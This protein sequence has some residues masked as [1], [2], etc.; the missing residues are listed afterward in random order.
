MSMSR[1]SKPKNRKTLR[2]TLITLAVIGAGALSYAGYLLHK[3]DTALKQ[4]SQPIESAVSK[5]SDSASNSASDSKLLKPMSFLLAGVDS[6]D[7]SGGSMNT[8]V[9]MMVSLNPERRSATIVSIPRDFELKPKAF[10]ISNQKA[11]YY[12]AYYNNQDKITSLTKTREFFGSMFDVPLDYMAVIDFDGFREVVDELGGLDINVD[13]DMRY[14]DNWDG[15]NINLKKGLQ[16]L[17]GKNTLDFLRYR[18]SNRGTEE[19]SDIARNE[20]QQLVLDK[21]LNKMTSLGGITQWGGILDIAGRNVKTDIP[22]ETLRKFILSFQKLKPDHIEFIHIDGRWDS[23][24]IVPKEEDLTAAIAALRTQLGLPAE[25]SASGST[26]TG[27]TYSVLRT[28]FGIDPAPKKPPVKS[29]SE[30]NTGGSG[31]SG[32]NGSVGKTGGSSG[33]GA[34]GGTNRLNTT[35]GSGSAGEDSFTRS[36]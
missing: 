28:K 11:N 7:G 8:D 2:N 10:G 27:S 32:T 34:T 21:L 25:S 20:R 35:S 36:R 33:S 13:M 1:L 24:Y 17:D 12:Y 15:T 5:P 4:M 23:P 31:T 6:R 29:S 3:A 26:V 30:S 22:A 18:K 9:L 19:S 14:V 16:R